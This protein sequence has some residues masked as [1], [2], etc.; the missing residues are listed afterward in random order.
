MYESVWMQAAL[1]GVV[2]GTSLT[3]QRVCRRMCDLSAAQWSSGR[4]YSYVTP[5]TIL[6][7]QP[8]CV[9]V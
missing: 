1:S 6:P 3:K 7:T 4:V 9:S 5:H 2:V 8:S